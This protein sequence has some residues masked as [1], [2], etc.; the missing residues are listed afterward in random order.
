MSIVDPLKIGT[1][2]PAF[3]RT[4]ANGNHELLLCDTI[5][6][7]ARERAWVAVTWYEA[8]RL[9]AAK[10]TGSAGSAA[11]VLNAPACCTPTGSP[12]VPHQPDSL[13]PPDTDTAATSAAAAARRET[14]RPRRNRDPFRSR[15]ARRKK[16]ASLPPRA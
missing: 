8:R 6:K 16:R 10:N 4:F 2:Q 11:C 14:R 9:S 7:S 15:R 5:A 3:P 12:D 13:F 1:L